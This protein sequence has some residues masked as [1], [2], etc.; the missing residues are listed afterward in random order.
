MAQ[1]WLRHHVDAQDGQAVIRKIVVCPA[2]DVEGVSNPA[3]VTAP[4]PESRSIA[5]RVAARLEA[6]SARITEN[7]HRR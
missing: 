5:E 4:A 3:P 7:R 1:N 2:S 6:N